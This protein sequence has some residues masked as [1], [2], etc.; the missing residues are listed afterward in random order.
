M[1]DAKFLLLSTAISY[2]ATLVSSKEKSVIL[3]QMIPTEEVLLENK[4]VVLVDYDKQEWY[5]PNTSYGS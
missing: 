1:E 3:Y 2:T 5:K 4:T